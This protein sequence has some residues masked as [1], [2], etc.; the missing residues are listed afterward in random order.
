MIELPTRNYIRNAYRHSCIGLVALMEGKMVDVINISE[1]GMKVERRFKLS[2]APV[3]FVLFRS[4]RHRHSVISRV[5]GQAVLMWSNLE[6]AGLTFLSPLHQE[7]LT[8][9]LAD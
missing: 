6:N 7:H 3:D 8:S 2:T 1:G 5:S 9:L 4:I